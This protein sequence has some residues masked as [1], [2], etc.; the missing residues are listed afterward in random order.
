MSVK[1]EGGKT[2]KE[3][4][5]VLTKNNIDGTVCKDQFDDND[6]KVI[7]KMLGF[8]GNARAVTDGRFGAGSGVVWLDDVNCK[9]Y[10]NSLNDCLNMNWAPKDCTHAE[11]IGV[12]CDVADA[13]SRAKPKPGAGCKRIIF[14]WRCLVRVKNCACFSGSVFFQ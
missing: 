3:G 5:V 7:C 1:L 11:D 13:G 9:G 10:E 12:Q 6:A 4:R 8:S 14:R 2:S